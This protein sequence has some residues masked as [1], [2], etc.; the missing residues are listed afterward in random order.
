MSFN[1]KNTSIKGVLELLCHPFLDERGS[2]FNI[3]RIQE[4]EFKEV[5]R[6]RSIAQVNLSRTYN[7]GAIRGLHLQSSPHEEA[8]I[9]RCIKGRVWDVAVDLRLDSETYRR[10]FAVELNAESCNSLLI[11]E[12]CAHGFQVLDP[13]SELLYLHSGRWE[14][15][16][17]IGI[18]WDD[19][20]LS[21]NWPLPPTDISVRDRELPYLSTI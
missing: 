20:E 8:K 1:I 18:R 21:I 11:P 17:E 9:I 13:C 16:S 7:V 15:E 12:G 19:N 6:D 4:K 2:F 5:W 3:F 14:K 10:W